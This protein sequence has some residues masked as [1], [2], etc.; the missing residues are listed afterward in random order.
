MEKLTLFEMQEIAGGKVVTR[1][2]YC[3]TLVMIWS[4]YD[5]EQLEKDFNSSYG[6]AEA[7]RDHCM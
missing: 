7:Y 1:K 4:N 3:A 5:E 6:F 2:E